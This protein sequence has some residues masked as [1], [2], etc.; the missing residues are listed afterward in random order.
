MLQRLL[1]RLIRHGRL[2][3]VTP[4]GTLAAGTPDPGHPSGLL[5]VG[6]RIRKT[7]TMLRIATNPDLYFGEAYMDGDLVVERGSFF[8]FMELLGSNIAVLG[9]DPNPKLGRWASRIVGALS[10]RNDPGKARANVAHHYDM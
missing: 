4:I 3:V 5:D 6:V 10:A 2:T 1:D 7:R 8:D 9:E